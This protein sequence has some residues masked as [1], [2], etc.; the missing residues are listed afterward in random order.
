MG[1]EQRKKQS[2]YA[3]MTVSLGAL[4]SSAA[5]AGRQTALIDNSTNKYVG[6]LL[7]LA[8]KLGTSPAANKSVYIYLIQ[9]NGTNRT[10]G[11]SASAGALTIKNASSIGI[12]TTGTAPLTGDVL[13]KTIPIEDLGQE[14]GIAI[15]QDSGANL[16]AT[17]GNHILS[18]SG[19]VWETVST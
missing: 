18:W 9:G 8:I 14:W 4:P 10:D 6:A 16:D 7:N 3:A 5:G 12:M 11:A 17:D 2:T 19:Y 13:R 1:I 15:V